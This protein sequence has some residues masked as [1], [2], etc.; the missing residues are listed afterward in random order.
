M[1]GVAIAIFGDVHGHLRLVFELCRRWQ[2]ATGQTLDAI[3]QCGDM[4]WFPDVARIDRATRK[5][6]KEDAEELGVA[7]FFAPAATEEDPRLD[8]NLEVVTA[9][10][11]W[12][13]GNHEDF[14]RLREVVGSRDLAAVDRFDRVRW[15]R[16]GTAITVGGARVGF[17]GGGPETL[18]PADPWQIVQVADAN[19]LAREALAILVTHPAPRGVGGESDRWGSAIV[20]KLVEKAQPAWHVFGHHRDPIAA[21]TLGATRCQWLNDTGFDR[22]GVLRRGC[23]A[24]YEDAR[25]R[26][27]DDPW[28]RAI[29][30]WSWLGPSR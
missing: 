12:A 7:R 27:V 23:M 19:R 21:V 9:A 6:A 13:H 1:A 30:K 3:L 24:I 2:E 4:G 11:Y 28:I 25:V 16:S 5:H 10:L 20:R 18:A 8:E 26:V 22:D 14:E 17:V 29:T 15:C